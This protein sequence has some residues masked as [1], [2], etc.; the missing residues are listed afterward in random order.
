MI[1]KKKVVFYTV[2][3]NLYLPLF[4]LYITLQ[5][6][7]LDFVEISNALTLMYILITTEVLNALHFKMAFGINQSSNKKIFQGLTSKLFNIKVSELVQGIICVISSVIV[8]SLIAIAFGAS[9]LSNY[10][11]T[12][13]FSLLLT[14][15]TVFPA[16]IHFNA[17]SAI[18]L[19]TSGQYSNNHQK[20]IL[21]K[22]YCTMLG[23]WF[24][25]FVIPLDW[26]RDWQAWPIPCCIG[27][28]VGTSL[29]QL[30]SITYLSDVMHQSRPGQGLIGKT[31]KRTR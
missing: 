18:S 9:V 8:F 11:Q 23:A 25:A 1:D 12:L 4:I 6:R 31:A 24:G 22:F 26:N 10:E 29:G 14:I 27:A 16:C 15:L 30:V 19:F 7:Y 21:Q 17:Q 13:N 2:W 5:E 28:L 3:S 20:I